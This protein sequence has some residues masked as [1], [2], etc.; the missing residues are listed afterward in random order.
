MLKKFY[1]N[2]AFM[3]LKVEC[4][5][6]YWLAMI[7]GPITAPSEVTGAS[8]WTANANRRGATRTCA[9]ETAMSINDALLPLVVDEGQRAR[10][11]GVLVLTRVGLRILTDEGFVAPDGGASASV[12]LR[13]ADRVDLESLVGNDVVV[14]GTFEDGGLTVDQI[15]DRPTAQRRQT[16]L[17]MPSAR[18]D[19]GYVLDRGTAA[20]AERVEAE[21][22]ELRE[23]SQALRDEDLA[24]SFGERRGTDGRL[25]STATVL[26]LPTWFATRLST[27]PA[28]TYEVGVLVKP[29][30]S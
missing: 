4:A 10:A 5:P 8:R 2:D 29:V 12:K 30:E 17:E 13:A 26:H 20:D 19:T 18:G 11:E 22:V 23:V 28:D 16:P 9:S 7:G 1:L 27:F 14:I 21:L 15:E 3:C 6:D 24:M 25:R